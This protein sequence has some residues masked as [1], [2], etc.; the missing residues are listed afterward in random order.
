MHMRAPPL[1]PAAALNPGRMSRQRPGTGGLPLRGLAHLAAS[2]CQ[3]PSGRWPQSPRD[4]LRAAG[5]EGVWGPAPFREGK[6]VDSSGR[7]LR[8]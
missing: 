4:A 2:C 6:S 7:K 5:R 8:V 1:C 3:V